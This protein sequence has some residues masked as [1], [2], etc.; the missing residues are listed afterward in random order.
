MG[1]L[2]TR[3]IA[4][5]L[6]AS[7][8]A[9]SLAERDLVL[10]FAG[11]TGRISAEMEHAWLLSDPRADELQSQRARFVSILDAILPA[12]RAREALSHRIE[13][14][15]AH[16]AI[17]SDAQFG[18]DPRRSKLAKRRAQTDVQICKT[19]LLDG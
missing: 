12:D 17:L 2:K 3:A 16:A 19:M 6:C 5:L 11:C 4:A 15:V 7:S 1:S 13:A 18:T 10:T 8:A 14:K 9:P